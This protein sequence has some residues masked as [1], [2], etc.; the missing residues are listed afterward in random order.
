MDPES[1]STWQ[2]FGRFLSVFLQSIWLFFPAILFIGLTAW[3]FW[4]LD[5]GKDL[6]VAFM[7]N[8]RARLYFFLA[9]A[10]WTYV[11]WY[12]SRFVCYLKEDQAGEKVKLL[13]AFPRLLG[14]GCLLTIGLAAMQ[15]PLSPHPLSG[16]RAILLLLLGLL[17]SALLDRIVANWSD[18][19]EKTVRVLFGILLVLFVLLLILVGAGRVIRQ[20]DIAGL[21]WTVFYIQ[22]LFLLYINLRRKKIERRKAEGIRPAAPPPVICRPIYRMMRFLRIPEAE[23]WYFI[24]FNL[25]SL[26]GLVIYCM[27]IGRMD[28]AVHIGPFPSVILAFAVLLG[29]ANILTCLSVKTRINFHFFV[30]LLAF[31]IP[32]VEN[33]YVRTTVLAP[34]SP[35][36][37]FHKRQTIHEYFSNWIKQRPELDSPGTNEY[38]VYFVLSNGGASRS[39]YWTASVLGRLEDSSIAGGDLFSRHVFCLSGTSGGGVGVASFF[40]LLKN[41]EG[42]PVRNADGL[43]IRRPLFEKSAKNLLGR[44]FLSYT[45]IRLVGP[46][47]F[48]Y[49]FHTFSHSDRTGALEA[50]F[51]ES[52]DTSSRSDQTGAPDPARYPIRFSMTMD[53]CVTRSGRPS[54]LPILCIN[55]TRMQDGNPA[56]VSNIE[57]SSQTFNGRVDVL[58]LLDSNQTMRLSTASVLGARFPY[59]SPAARVDQRIPGMNSGSK[60]DSC[61]KAHYFVDGG[62]FD[63][64]GAGV[65]Q[66]MITAIIQDIAA[67]RDPV[68]RARSRKLN[69]IIL[70]ITNSPLGDPRIQQTDPL[71]NDLM[72]PGLTLLGAYNMQTAINDKRLTGY[73]SEINRVGDSTNIHSATYL[74]IHLYRDWWDKRDSFAVEN[75][76]MNWFI[77]DTVRRR[78]DRRLNEQPALNELVRSEMHTPGK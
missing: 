49:I 12:S 1:L 14:F 57:I 9:I 16:S 47:Y 44:D 29:F 52:E 37:V 64:S 60:P 58:D 69:F 68:I 22:V 46:D 51:E 6:V 59:I 45:L 48:K 76:T 50:T 72:S 73:L 31:V 25:F 3:C 19:K 26:L 32:S 4:S 17:L 28:L 10:F 34:S 27:E 62:Y 7:E 41:T 54:G 40:A 8:P 2:K 13:E 61:C 24:W 33:H 23:L 53:S 77:S 36:G 70:H 71:N 56:V 55:T 15:S 66:E 63:N 65:V 11:S 43:P 67:S 74:P 75:Y 39:A 78:M 20:Y 35:A 5:Q 42:L 30:F 38:P 18:K 21:F